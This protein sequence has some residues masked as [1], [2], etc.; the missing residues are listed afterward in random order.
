LIDKRTSPPLKAFLSIN[1]NRAMP[2][3]ATLLQM[4]G[5]AIN[6]AIN[7]HKLMNKIS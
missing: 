1:K 4:K 7:T 3:I 5:Y 6:N 2:F